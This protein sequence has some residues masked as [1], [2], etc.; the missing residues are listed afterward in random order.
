VTPTEI[1]RLNQQ[2]V[3]KVEGNV[4]QSAK[5]GDIKKAL[6]KIVAKFPPPA[7]VNVKLGGDIERM[8]DAFLQLG[9]V[10]ILGLI[11]VY[12][13][14][15][16]QFENYLDPFIIM[17]SVPFALTGVFLTIVITRTTFNMYSF[18]GMIMLL[19]VV[20]NNAIVY[21]DYANQLRRKGM[22]MNDALILAGKRR[23]RPILMTTITTLIG[24]LPMSLTREEGAEFWRPIGISFIGG[25]TVSTLVTLILIPTIYHL[26]YEWLLKH[27]RG[28]R[29]E[30]VI[31]ETKGY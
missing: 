7:G 18:L 10:A 17:F 23:L 24:M 16:A 27:G 1:E 19:G 29:Q 2:R 15:A 26:I 28:I 12:M 14:M 6:E 8:A 13:V 4:A 3:V 5:L 20:V 9:F 22:E 31:D 11:L 25:M 21:V 30:I